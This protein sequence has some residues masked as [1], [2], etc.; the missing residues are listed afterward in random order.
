MPHE[1]ALDILG[2][3]SKQ[4]KLDAELLRIFIEAGVAQEALKPEPAAT[5]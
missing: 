4:G 1:R 2:A 5:S 3:E